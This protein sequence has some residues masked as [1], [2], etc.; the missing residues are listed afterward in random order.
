[1]EHELL[2]TNPGVHLVQN[3]VQIKYYHLQKNYPIVERLVK[4]IA[5]WSVQSEI[6]GPSARQITSTSITIIDSN[7]YFEPEEAV[8]DAQQ[9]QS[10]LLKEPWNDNLFS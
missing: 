3:V 9:S 2:V 4:T 10:I 6:T 8:F 5:A 1:M 7:F